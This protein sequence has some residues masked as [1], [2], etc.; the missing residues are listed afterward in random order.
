MGQSWIATVPTPGNPEPSL[1]GDF[2]FDGLVNQIDINL[3]TEQMRSPPPDLS[4]DLTADGKVNTDDRDTMI[5]DVVA[6]DFGDS[7]LDSVFNSTDLVIVFQAGEYEDEVA[8]NSLWETGDWNGDGEFGSSDLVLAFQKGGY[9]PAGPGALDI[10]AIAAALPHD[11]LD[12]ADLNEMVTEQ[13]SVQE[14]LRPVAIELIDASLESLFEAAF[15]L[16][17]KEIQEL[18]SDL[19]ELGQLKG[20]I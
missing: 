7:N 8:L 10:R 18:V 14:N 1:V 12:G 2:N 6:T 13:I 15:E 16:D 4:F 5:E 11:I 3:L 19:D 9:T 17:E 20:R